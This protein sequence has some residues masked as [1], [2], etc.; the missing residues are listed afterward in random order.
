[1][2]DASQSRSESGPGGSEPSGAADQLAALT[3]ELE[4]QR[5]RAE[6]FLQNWQRAQADFT[7]FRRRTEQ[8][9]RDA[10]FFAEAVLIAR[11]LGVADDLARALATVPASLQLFTWVEG[12][13]L[14]ERK[15]LAIFEAHGLQPIEAVGK[16]FDPSLHEAVSSREGAEGM[17]LEELQK[18]YRLHDRVL[19]P[20]LVV[21]G[22]A[23]AGATPEAGQSE[24]GQQGPR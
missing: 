3:R 12:L 6:Q 8:E 21:I 19:R 9:K 15:L 24:G 2:E 22:K 10:A 4:E 13:H 23:A 14:L 5:A 11:L 7:N 17:V 18:G 16:P 20:A 1:M